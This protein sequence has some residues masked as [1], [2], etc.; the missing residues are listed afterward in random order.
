MVDGELGARRLVLR[1]FR[2]EPGHTP[3]LHNET[4][5]DVMYVVSGTGT[6]EAGGGAAVELAPGTGC[7][8]PP[9]VGYR[10]ENEGPHDLVM[11][12]VLSPPPGGPA[13]DG[14]PEADR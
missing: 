6:L 5:E 8:V 10:I 4:S 7:W 14:Y 12:S 2:F 3:D 11:V 1:V 13:P 9:G